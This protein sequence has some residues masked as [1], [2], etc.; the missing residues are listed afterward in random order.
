[1]GNIAQAVPSMRG[2]MLPL[3]NEVYAHKFDLLLYQNKF[4]DMSPTGIAFYFRLGRCLCSDEELRDEL[5][6]RQF[7]NAAIQVVADYQRDCET[8]T[9]KEFYRGFVVGEIFNMLAQVLQENA[10]DE[11]FVEKLCKM[12]GQSQLMLQCAIDC[13][14]SQTSYASKTASAML[15]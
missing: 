14:Q 6:A 8:M 1:M 15:R 12:I 5:A 9:N 2:G 7:F 11:E 10:E 4:K 13:C 3:Q